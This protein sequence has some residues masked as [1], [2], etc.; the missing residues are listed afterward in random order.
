MGYKELDEVC[1]NNFYLI[2]NAMKANG[3]QTTHDTM[4]KNFSRKTP[5][6]AQIIH[7]RTRHSFC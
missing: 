1:L 6:S 5:G 4:K 7:K 2:G 3:H